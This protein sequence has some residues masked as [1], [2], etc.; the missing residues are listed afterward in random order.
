MAPE[1]VNRQPYSGQPVDLFALGVIL[2]ILYSGHPPF[3]MAS[4]EDPHFNTLANE[5]AH[6]FWQ[7]HSQNKPSN[8]YGEH[9]KS[10]I[11]MMLQANPRERISTAEIVAHPWLASGG[12]ADEEQP[13]RTPP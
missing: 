4:S 9:F 8:F 10:L 11:T 13:R 12:I 2:F 1:I 5:H 7:G 6:L 3:R